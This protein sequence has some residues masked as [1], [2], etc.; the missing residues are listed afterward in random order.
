MITGDSMKYLYGI[1]NSSLIA[2][3]MRSTGIPTGMG[4]VQWDKFAI[5]RIPIPKLT[6]AEQ[7]PFIRLVDRILKEKSDN[8]KADTTVLEWDI[9]DLVYDLY[10]LTETEIDEIEGSLDTVPLTAAQQDAAMLNAMLEGR[11]AAKAEG[12][13]SREEVMAILA[14]SDGN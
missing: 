1:L 3:F 8:P 5:E 2:W 12:Y 11:E 10:G 9:N 13:A 6:D 14:D 7:K 4:L